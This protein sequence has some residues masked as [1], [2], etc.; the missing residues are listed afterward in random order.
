MLPTRYKQSA[1]MKQKVKPLS[2]PDHN[3]VMKLFSD[4][5]WETQ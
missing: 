2:L 3:E 4:W 1:E 5:R